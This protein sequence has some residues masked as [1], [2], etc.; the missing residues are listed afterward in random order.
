M[1]NQK[2]ITSQEYLDGLNQQLSELK[3][4]KTTCIDTLE[5]IEHLNKERLLLMKESKWK[6]V[7]SGTSH[8]RYE[9]EHMCLVKNKMTANQLA[10][11]I[12]LSNNIGICR[13]SLGIA[14]K[15]YESKIKY[16]KNER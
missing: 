14:V 6:E 2:Y 10:R 3:S 1:E 16:L 9:R 15:L 13:D 5:K 12:R 4:N 8:I 11:Y 7:Y